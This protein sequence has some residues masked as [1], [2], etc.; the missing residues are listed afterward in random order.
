MFAVG[1]CVSL[2]MRYKKWCDNYAV[3]VGITGLA[4]SPAGSMQTA[5]I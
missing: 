3:R 2:P 4:A 1:G 5:G